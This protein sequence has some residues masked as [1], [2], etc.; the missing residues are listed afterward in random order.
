MGR[1]AVLPL[2]QPQAVLAV[3]PGLQPVLDGD[4]PGW[5]WTGPL[6]GLAGGRPADRAMRDGPRGVV[7]D[8]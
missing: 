6:A 8:R 1:P 7:N 2:V 3:S 5:A 4:H